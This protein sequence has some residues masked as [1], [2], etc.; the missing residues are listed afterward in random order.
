MF[1]WKAINYLFTVKCIGKY[2]CARKQ[3]HSKFKCGKCIFWTTLRA[4]LNFQISHNKI[5]N[6]VKFQC[7]NGSKMA[8][9]TNYFPWDSQCTILCFSLYNSKNL[10]CCFTKRFMHVQCTKV[11]FNE[12]FEEI[13]QHNHIDTPSVW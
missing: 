6:A 5:H 7:K 10:E 2:P 11:N 3:W 1:C 13:L 8:N 12:V 9:K 4:S